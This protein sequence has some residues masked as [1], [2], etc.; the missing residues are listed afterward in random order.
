[1]LRTGVAAKVT[2]E[3]NSPLNPTAG[4]DRGRRR[5]RS[6]LERSR[7]KGAERV[8]AGHS[9]S[10]GGSKV[11]KRGRAKGPRRLPC[12]EVN[13]R[14]FGRGQWGQRELAKPKSFPASRFSRVNICA[15]PSVC[16]ATAYGREKVELAELRRSLPGPLRA[17]APRRKTQDIPDRQKLSRVAHGAKRRNRQKPPVAVYAAAEGR[18]KSRRPE[19]FRS[20][21]PSFLPIGNASRPRRILTDRRFLEYAASGKL[22][23]KKRC[24]A[25]NGGQ[26]EESPPNHWIVSPGSDRCPGAV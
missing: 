15:P 5:K 16:V 3:T 20:R 21:P 12:F 11:R 26:A 14:S 4:R 10:R 22:P 8:D 1:M 19:Y 24:R 25:R 17:G 13:I 23:A 18:L 9:A 6:P 7:R 2:E